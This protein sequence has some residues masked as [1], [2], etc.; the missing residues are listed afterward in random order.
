MTIQEDEF[1][2]SLTTGELVNA[3]EG[4]SYIVRASLVPE[5]GTF[6]KANLTTLNATLLD[7]DTNTVINNRENQNIL[8]VNQ[9]YVGDDGAF[10]LSLTPTDTTLLNQTK[11]RETRLLILK[12]TWEDENSEIQTGI[13]RARFY[14]LNTESSTE[15]VLAAAS[16]VLDTTGIKRVKTKHIEVET[17]DPRHVQTAR[18]KENATHPTFCSLSFCKGTPK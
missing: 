5:T 14:T 11:E 10:Q 16:S 13:L 7:V 8:D 3:N 12:W 4:E 1:I 15:A 18:D 2:R 17:H 6:V 9:G